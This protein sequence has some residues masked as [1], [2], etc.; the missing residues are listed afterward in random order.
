MA[1]QSDEHDPKDLEKSIA[2]GYELED[3]N[4]RPFVV[5]MGILLVGCVGVMVA[6]YGLF[7]FL[8]ARAERTKG[9]APEKTATMH[10]WEQKL[11][12]ARPG[13]LLPADTTR[14]QVEPPIQ[15]HPQEDLAELRQ[16]NDTLLHHYGWVDR[17]LGTVH[18]PIE[19]ALA[20][21]AERGLPVRKS[22]PVPSG[23][24]QLRS[25]ASPAPSTSAT[26]ADTATVLTSGGAARGGTASR[27]RTEA[28][29]DE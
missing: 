1:H 23:P 9:P 15:W 5:F 6:L 24:V 28:D 16:H 11:N 13:S 10:P 17:G 26:V 2:I 8:E 7:N 22:A 20:I 14:T 21:T 27:N 12:P 18:I 25:A 29:E 4:V 19:R 3:V